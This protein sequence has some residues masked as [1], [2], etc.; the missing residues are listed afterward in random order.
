M[1]NILSSPAAKVQATASLTL[2]LSLYAVLRR[3]GITPTTAAASINRMVNLLLSAVETNQFL[4]AMVYPSVVGL[5]W[6][7]FENYIWKELRTRFRA[8][9]YCSVTISSK[10]ENFKAVIDFVQK[11]AESG[12]T[13]LLAETKKKKRDRKSWIAQWNGIGERQPP[14][15][16]YRPAKSGATVT[17]VWKGAEIYLWRTRGQTVTTGY[18]RIP[19]ELE[20]MTIATWAGNINVLK[21][22]MS[23]AIRDTFEEAGDETNVFVLSD[24]WAGGW[25]KALTKDRRPKESIVLDG[26]LSDQLIADARQFLDSNQWYADRGIPYR[27]GYLLHGPPGCGKTSFTQ[28]LAGALK[29]DMCM[30]S[31][32]N[33]LLDDQKLAQNFRE[34]P[35]NAIILLEDVDAV[36]VD[37]DV[38]KKGKGG[39]GTGV[40]FS[41]LLNAIDGVASQEGRLFFMTTNYPEKLD[42]ALVRPGRC[43]VKLELKCASRNQMQRLFLRFFPNAGDL[44]AKRFAS[45]LPEFELS[46]AQLQ[47]H[48]L[49]YRDSSK[50]AVDQVPNLLRAS[51]PQQ[52][53]KMTT[54]EHLK[55]VGL[56]RLAPLFE[57][58]GYRYKSDLHGL[59]IKT[60]MQW[61]IE[62]QYDHL[63]CQRLKRLLEEEK[64]L[65]ETEYPLA[66]IATIR[67]AFF[68]AYPTSSMKVLSQNQ[69]GEEESED[70]EVDGE[71][72]KKVEERVRE[73][74]VSNT[75]LP[76]PPTLL[77][78][79]SY[80]QQSKL[81]P[82]VTALKQSRL[83]DSTSSRKPMSPR[84]KLRTIKIETKLDNLAK[85]ISDCLSKDGKGDVSLWQLRWLLAQNPYPEYAVANASS[86]NCS[87][88]ASTRV[89]SPMTCYSWLLRAGF[90]DLWFHF[91]DANYKW[92]YEL[93]LG[94]KS[95]KEL[96]AIGLPTKVATI[97]DRLIQNDTKNRNTTCVML[98]PDR[99][100]IR[101]KF[102]L[103]W[104]KCTHDQTHRFASLLTDQKG[105]GKCSVRQLDKYLF[106]G[107]VSVHD[108]NNE[109]SG[110]QIEV[111]TDKGRCHKSPQAAV[112]GCLSALINI[113]K[114]P[115]PVNPSK[116]RP[117]SWIHK[118]LSKL[119][120]SFAVYASKLSDAGLSKKEEVIVSPPLEDGDLDK[121]GVSKLGHRRTILRWFECLRNGEDDGV[122]KVDDRL[123][124]NYGVGRVVEHREEDDMYK[125]EMSWGGTVFGFEEALKVERLLA[126]EMKEESKSITEDNEKYEEKYVVKEEPKMNKKLF[127]FDGTP[128]PKIS[129]SIHHK[130]QSGRRDQTHLEKNQQ[131]KNAK[132][133][134]KKKKN[135]TRN[136]GSD[137]K[138]GK[139]DN[140]D[141]SINH[142]DEKEFPSL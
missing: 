5:V 45:S 122:L 65:M 103:A 25:E 80:E 50:E 8:L 127:L 31:L 107:D 41:G 55:R 37:R 69:E 124:C 133:K 12:N 26:T 9:F 123:K 94:L 57:M 126:E 140:N 138:D 91:E 74:R 128:K 68:A 19:L 42:S 46:M 38:Q 89:H 125:I 48:L 93:K 47:G 102:R 79:T 29:L 62:L 142:N 92:A 35:E 4:Q 95:V 49:E 83:N 24:S 141:S 54:W 67:D 15:M 115:R 99:E 10:D 6:Y 113:M 70:S 64:K 104:P 86:L 72:G 120:P 40:S 77:R 112:D 36:F 66:S 58:H 97:L 129:K 88:G 34:A 22:F 56:E 85:K 90:D 60:I 134:K 109:E 20:E 27:R 44:E 105:Y 75:D 52:V 7:S 17:F 28:V 101:H 132:K 131:E 53:K 76:Q 33:N 137:S 135:N 81:H 2:V 3:R 136:G 23:T 71:E 11:T 139:D 21:E 32:S 43:D 78:Q 61:D 118:T 110:E 87:R 119:N 59:D 73:K 121:L 106:T 116:P 114:K 39:G 63:Q 111:S 18:N 117:C 14:E 13:L 98:H 100:R 84:T 82:S 130:Q 30:L 96:K 1:G 51:K 108:N 16:E